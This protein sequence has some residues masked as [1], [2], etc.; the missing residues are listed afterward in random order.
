MP[1][2]G[3]LI[4]KGTKG[5]RARTVPIIV[6]PQDGRPPHGRGQAA[7][8]SPGRVAAGSAPPACATP[9]HGTRWSPRSATST[10]AATTFGTPG[11]PGWPKPAYRSTSYGRSPATDAHHNPAVP[12]P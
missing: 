2:P 9:P 3:G 10:Y 7:D 6:E 11:S 5:K 8:C 12:T 4:D 1:G